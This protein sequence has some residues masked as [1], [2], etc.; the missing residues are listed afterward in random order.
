MKI[1]LLI[2]LFVLLSV[3]VFAT[4]VCY[5]NQPCYFYHNVVSEEFDE[6][7]INVINEYGFNIIDD[8][9]RLF[10]NLTYEYIYTFSRI[11]LF[12][13]TITELND[14]VVLETKTAQFNIVEQTTFTDEI[15]NNNTIFLIILF[16]LILI[17]IIGLALNIPPLVFLSCFGWLLMSIRMFTLFTDYSWIGAFTGLTSIALMLYYGFRG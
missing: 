16:L 1:I 14:S 2:L 9:M 3:S 13:L 7:N 6:V 15:R 12:N 5:L 8:D 17:G 11:G 10:H 4:P